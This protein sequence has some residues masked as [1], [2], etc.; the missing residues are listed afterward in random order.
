MSQESS[1]NQIV[2]HVPKNS[3]L[4][5]AA[6]HSLIDSKNPPNIHLSTK[7]KKHMTQTPILLTIHDETKSKLL[8]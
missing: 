1:R 5:F 7:S 2:T 3:V 8:S 4:V 6:V